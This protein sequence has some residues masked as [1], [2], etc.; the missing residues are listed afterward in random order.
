MSTT[1]DSLLSISDIASI[2]NVCQRTLER[3]I[4]G[5]EFPRSDLRIGKLPRWSRAT[6]SE[7]IA[8]GG[9]S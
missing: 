7:W 9:A 4:A 5:G 2:L 8:K 3:M 6:V 1:I